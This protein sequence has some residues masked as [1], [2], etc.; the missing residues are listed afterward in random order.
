MTGAAVGKP[1]SQIAGHC[2]VFHLLAFLS[3]VFMYLGARVQ[4]WPWN[5]EG[6]TCFINSVGGEF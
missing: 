1:G 2:M 5:L 4:E 6:H 3:Y